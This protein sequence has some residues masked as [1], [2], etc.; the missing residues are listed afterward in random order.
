MI[1]LVFFLGLITWFIWAVAGWGGGLI[2][3][4]ALMFLWLPPQIA[5]ATNKLG[6]V[7]MSI[8]ALIKFRKKKKIIWRLSLPLCLI[9]IAWWFVGANILVNIE[10]DILN[11]VIWI[12]LIILLPFVFIKNI[13]IQNT[14]TSLIKK[15][16]WGI[17]YFFLTIFG[18]FFGGWT[19]PLIM[20]DLMFFFGL[21]IIHANATDT[22]PWILLGIT[23]L[24][25]MVWQGLVDRTM[26]I[27]LFLG[28]FLWWY[29][30]AHTAIKKWVKRVKIFFAVIVVASAAKILLF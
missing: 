20:A 29:L 9:A 22:F 4:P 27:S 12:L 11:R 13:G 3:I 2:S 25:V 19:W 16:I 18:W 28:M 21:D 30:G 6:G 24:I 14:K 23:S 26:W 5:I 10:A 1:F 7:G 8:G 17:L 15:I